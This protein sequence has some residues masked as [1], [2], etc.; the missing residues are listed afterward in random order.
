M[1]LSELPKIWSSQFGLALAPLFERDEV[2]EYEKHYVLL[3]GGHGTFALSVAEDEIWRDP[4]NVAA[5]AWS[6]DSP[7]H[8]TVTDTKVAV[9]RW[10]QPSSVHVLPRSAVDRSLDDF[11]RFLTNDR[12]RSTKTVIDHLLSLFRKVRSLAYGADLPDDR[13]TDVFLLALAHLIVPDGAG[14]SAGPWGIAEDTDDL[15]KSLNPRGLTS[16]LDEIRQATGSL[17]LLKLYPA[18]A[19]RHAGGQLFQEAHFELFRAP[20]IDLFG[21]VGAPQLK[22]VSRGGAHFTPPALARIL[23]EQ[24]FA[25]IGDVSNRDELTICDP[26]CGSGAFLHEALRALRRLGFSGRLTLVGQDVSK[27]AITMAGFALRCARNDWSPLG[28]L[29]ITLNVADSLASRAIPPSDI[30]IMNPPFISWGTQTPEQRIQL[31]AALGSGRSSRGDLSM[32]FV[33]RAMESLKPGGVLG[34]LFP[35][36]LL[37]L[38]AS[39][40]WRTQLT[41]FGDVRLLAS[42]GDYG[43]FTQALVQVACAVISKGSAASDNRELTALVSSDDSRATGDALR[44]LRKVGVRPP[45]IPITEKGWSIFSL[46]TDALRTRV[47]WRFPSPEADAAI[48][49]IEEALPQTINDL[50]EVQKGIET[51]LDQALLLTETEWQKLPARERAHFRVATMSDS[52][53]NAAVV[54]P[55]YVFFPYSDEGPL[56]SDAE[57]VKKAVPQFFSRHLAPYQ[58]RLAD[59]AQIRRSGR[60]DWWGLTW[61]RE[62]ST[63]R[64]PRIVTKYFTA[65]GGFV[66]DYDAKFLPVKG[67]A[68]F[69]TE[70]LMDAADEVLETH[71]L[72]SAYVGLFNSQAFVKLLATY[73]PHVSG[74]QFT[75]EARY[76][77]IIP[78]P[79]LAELALDPVRGRLVTGLAKLGAAVDVANAHWRTQT[80]DIVSDLYGNDNIAGL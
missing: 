40:D 72:L 53:R 58:T 39:A 14:A 45:T 8:V 43:L 54:R 20:P 33:V 24:A 34:T 68:W 57:A 41:E 65:E 71:D 21:H 66:G 30:I 67:F 9:L 76:V 79:N 7:H 62:W 78:L 47:T 42:I 27:P 15:Y 75:L 11:Y 44:C 49:R 55:Y 60:Q 69:P 59:R 38:Q 19:I 77:D 22:K 18:L 51:G 35:A 52:I 13:S 2:S 5:W 64:T 16:A 50:F 23:V 1:T 63:K 56:F 28:G 37:S 73:S 74:G 12:L 46:P 61:P 26:A 25:N 31:E 3:D 48:R 80:N 36:S 17:A 32:A 6:S 29:Y 4:K 10:D 70:L